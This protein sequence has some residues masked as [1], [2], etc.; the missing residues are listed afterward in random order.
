MNIGHSAV[1]VVAQH[2]VH[3]DTPSGAAGQA[4]GRTVDWADTAVPV[5]VCASYALPPGFWPLNPTS[6]NA[7]VCHPDTMA[8]S[9]AGDVSHCSLPQA[10]PS[11]AQPVRP[12]RC[13]AQVSAVCTSA[14]SRGEPPPHQPATTPP[15]PA[16]GT[17]SGARHGKRRCILGADGMPA[18]SRARICEEVRYLTVTSSPHATLLRTTRMLLGA[19]RR[20]QQRPLLLLLFVSRGTPGATA[21]LLALMPPA[22]PPPPQLPRETWRIAR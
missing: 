3:V 20:W 16:G 18:G 14:S 15:A 4:G 10:A 6:R 2:Q 7:E 11:T 5:P 21:L 12:S 8:L 1:K 22:A 17:V 19:G 13:A 9:H